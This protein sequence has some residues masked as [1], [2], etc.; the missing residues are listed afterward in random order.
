MKTIYLD[1]A[2]TTAVDGTVLKEMLPYFSRRFGNASTLYTLGHE[3]REAVERARKQ[4]AKLINAEPNEIFFTSGGTES[5]NTALK[6][7]F[8]AN[9]GKKHIIT[10]KIEHPAILQTCKWIEKQGGRVTYLHV[11]ANGIVNPQSVA[12][13]IGEDTLLVSIMHANNEIGTIQPI[14]EI[15]RICREKKVMFHTDAVQ[16]FGKIPID[17]KKMNIDMLSAS[18]HKIYGP[19]GT[20]ILFKRNKIWIDALMHGGGQERGLRSGTENVAGIVGFGKAA[21][22]AMQKMKSEGE[23]E[24]KLRDKIING[25]LK[26]P[27]SRLNGHPTK[28]LPGNVNISFE[29]I[30][31]ESMVLMLNEKGICSSTGSACSTGSLEPSHVLL[32]IGMTHEQAHGSLRLTLGR[33]T[34]AKDVGYVLKAV[35]EIVDKLR[36]MSATWRE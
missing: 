12:N 5:D 1:H 32:A 18:S 34:S 36:S 10:T 15:A 14:E 6:G 21:E 20:G 27:K 29:G 23:R 26:I 13:A 3:S 16:T 25:L 4:I 11:D 8:L 9:A 22:I 31:G 19:K 33:E 2:A 35:P 17:V 7:A 28:R 30:E 24:K